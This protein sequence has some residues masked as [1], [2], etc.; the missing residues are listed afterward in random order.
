MRT[1]SR[2]RSLPSSRPARASSTSSSPAATTRSRSS[3]S[4]DL[5]LIANEA[6]FAGQ[7]NNNEYY[8][9]LASSDLLTDNPYLDTRPVPASGRQLFVPD[10]AGGRLVETPAQ[11]AGAVTSFENSSGTLRSSTAFVSGYDFVTDGSQQ[12]AQRLRSILGGTSVQ[13]A[14]RHE[15]PVQPRHLLVEERAL[16]RGASRPLG[17]AAIND[18]NGH[19]DNTRALMANGDLLS[20]SELD[21]DARLLRRHLPHDGLPRRLPDDGRDHRDARRS[22]GPQYFAGTGTGFVGNTGLRPRQHRQRRV[23]R[24]ADG[25]LRRPPRRHRLD[26][27]GAQPREGGLLPLA[28]RLQLLRR[29]DA[30]RGRALRP[31]DVRR[32]QRL[33]PR[34]ARARPGAGAVARPGATARRARRAPRKACSP[35]SPERR[36]QAA[37][38]AVT[39][40]FSGPRHRPARQLLHERRPGSG[41][42]LPAAA[43]VRDAVRER[44]GP[45]RARRRDRQPHQR[46]SHRVRPGQRAADARPDRK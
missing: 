12:V 33:R 39:P 5:S 6:G 8:G 46:G 35:R 28:R 30:L 18:W 31:A 14:A 37:G 23:L 10:L 25:G 21:G 13:H 2:T 44:A 15:H 29:E 3:G 16:Q 1:R 7:F 42:E 11:I 41:A 22:T 40:A 43:A 32:R 4:P 38:F 17:Q 36:V 26:R 45:G 19:Y 9:A 34:S 24:R 20:T 27:P